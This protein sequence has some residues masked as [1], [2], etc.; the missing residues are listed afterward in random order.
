[1][2]RAVILGIVLV[3]VAVAAAIGLAVFEYYAGENPLFDALYERWLRRQDMAALERRRAENPR[4]TTAVVTLTTLPSRID[5]LGPTIKSLLNQTVAPAAIRLNLPARSRREQT[6]YVVPDWLAGLSAVTICPCEDYG[7]STKLLPALL[8]AAPDARLIV[9]DDDRI[10]H[11]YFIEQMVRHADAYPGVAIVG[12]GWDAPAD[13]TDRPSTLLATLAGAP[14]V[15]IK[16]TRVHG[17]RE[18]D[19]MQGL[20]GYLVEPRFFDAA[21]IVD[22]Q[23]TPPAAFLVD[24]VWISAHCRVPKLIVGGR[25]TNFQSMRD[26]TFYQRTSLGRVNRGDGTLEGRHNTIMLRYFKDRWKTSRKAP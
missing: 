15:P 25:R 12:S 23:G 3:S 2:A 6:P 21:A 17:A 22:Y 19:I 26:T 13:L 14:P 16:C 18:V 9:V 10:Y 8:A 4:R 20:S 5:R 7:P 1:M 11:P 24:D